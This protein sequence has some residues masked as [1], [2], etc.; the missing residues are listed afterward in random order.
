MGIPDCLCRRNECPV[1]VKK[2]SRYCL[3]DARSERLKV[4]MLWDSTLFFVGFLE[5]KKVENGI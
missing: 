4:N 1:F 2:S 3:G 5:R